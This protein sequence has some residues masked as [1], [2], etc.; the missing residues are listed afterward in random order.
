[1][2][3]QLGHSLEQVIQARGATLEQTY[4][5][6]TGMS[7]LFDAMTGVVEPFFP[8]GGPVQPRTDD[9][10]PLYPDGARR[11]V[12][13]SV[14]EQELSRTALPTVP[15]TRPLPFPCRGDVDVRFTPYDVSLKL[16]V[17]AIPL[18]FANPQFAWTIAG[19]PV[20]A[21]GPLTVEVPVVPN[22]PLH[23]NPPLRRL[24][25]DLRSLTVIA[26]T[27]TVVPPGTLEQAGS[28]Q[29]EVTLPAVGGSI[30]LPLS[31][32]VT[33]AAPTVL[34]G[35]S[36]GLLHRGYQTRQVVWDEHWLQ[37]AGD[38]RA[39]AG[40]LAG[41]LFK[42]IFGQIMP[43][44]A[45]DFVRAMEQLRELLAELQVAREKKDTRTA[46]TLTGVMRDYLNVPAAVLGVPAQT[47]PRLA[48][49][50]TQR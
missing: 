46:D 6:L 25:S 23:P 13:F 27:P 4:R 2:T 29:F 42:P 50:E 3:S 12:T 11:T 33:D 10:F 24:H 19:A 47:P 37:Q 44:P 20:N 30:D 22:D 7:G 40:K 26:G 14:V 16:T 21:A 8:T 41:P 36:T 5:N 39:R 35:G 28:G 49:A 1:M 18:G 9:P 43:D 17:Q 32:T 15:V 45:P 34:G 38:C 31:C 48:P